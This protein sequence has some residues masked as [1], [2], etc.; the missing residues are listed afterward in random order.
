MKLMVSWGHAGWAAGSGQRDRE[1]PVSWALLF[2][3]ESFPRKLE[4]EKALLHSRPAR[5]P[6]SRAC[7]QQG[8]EAGSCQ[9]TRCTSS[10]VTLQESGQTLCHASLGQSC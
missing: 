5:L 8:L 3:G 4:A 10:W 1:V 6:G 9:M 2:I 7:G